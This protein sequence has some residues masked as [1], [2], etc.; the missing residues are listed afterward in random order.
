[1]F[2]QDYHIRQAANKFRPLVP[3]RVTY[4]LWFRLAAILIFGMLGYLIWAQSRGLL[5]WT[6]L[7]EIERNYLFGGLTSFFIGV[8]FYWRWTKGRNALRE[9]EKRKSLFVKDDR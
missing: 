9:F 8:F 2:D 5:S 4:W 1:M 3:S 7:W 6:E